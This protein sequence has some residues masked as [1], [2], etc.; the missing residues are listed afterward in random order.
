MDPLTPEHESLYQ[1]I[2]AHL[3]SLC[4]ET[5]FLPRLVKENGWTPAF[6]QRV[7]DEYAKFLFI[8]K[9]A[10]HEVSPSPIIDKAWHLHLLHTE[11]YWNDLC[12]NIL[13]MALHHAP[14]T[15]NKEEDTK[16]T[17]WTKNTLNSYRG[18]FGAPS[19]IWTAPDR[20]SY[21]AS[22]RIGA[23]VMGG[24]SLGSFTGLIFAPDVWPLVLFASVG[25][26]IPA[27]ILL[28]GARSPL[29]PTASKFGSSCGGG[30]C[31]SDSG[32]SGGGHSCGGHSCGGHGCGG[33]GSH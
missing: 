19:L 26:S 29:G 28:L 27:I 7:M 32:H 4:S 17:D 33:G 10:G 5:Q 21:R 13:Q 11:A 3:T 25:F 1:K 15:G 31:S 22:L 14:H 20:T 8:A 2:C 18:F 6:A 23:Y 12:P 9:V 30:T 16:F 24:V